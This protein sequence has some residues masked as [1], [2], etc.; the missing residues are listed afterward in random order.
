M[1]GKTKKNIIFEMAVP[2]S[3][4]QK[5]R[6]ELKENIIREI[7]EYD[8]KYECIITVEEGFIGARS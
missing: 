4:N 2:Y 7:K 6:E 8:R 5:K 1:N 3:Y